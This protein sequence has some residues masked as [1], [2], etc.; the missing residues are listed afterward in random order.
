MYELYPYFTND[1]TVGLFSRQD[2]D[3]YHSTYGALTESWQ[4][5]IIPSGLKEHLKVNNSVKILDICYGIGYNSKT[6]LNVFINEVTKKENCFKNNFNKKF[7]NDTNDIEAIYTDNIFEEF[8]HENRIKKQNLDNKNTIYSEAIHT[9]NLSST[10]FKEILI[11]AVDLDKILIELS[12][13][14]N[15]NPKNCLLIPGED[16][17]PYSE[18]NPKLSQVKRMRRSFNTRLKKEF[19]LKKEV[20]IILLEKLSE[21]F[22]LKNDKI[23]QVILNEK[24]Y[25]LFLS[26]Y[27]VNLSK[28]YKNQGYNKRSKF[29]LSAFIHNI[30]YRYVS[31]S[32]K[33]ALKLLKTHKIDMNFYSEDARMFIKSTNHTYDYIF[34]DA[35]T[36]TKCPALWT[37]EFL[38]LLYTKLNENGMIL[39]YSNSAAVRNA[40]LKNGFY[41]GKNYDPELNKFIG[42]VATKNDNLI[43]YPLSELDFDLIHSKAGI[44]FKDENLSSNDNNI[45]TRRA[46]EVKQSNLA[47]SSNILRGHKNEK[48]QPL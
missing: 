39:T 19:K 11:D 47:S 27:M 40:F 36:P 9:D 29:N 18:S 35:F 41:V 28:Y 30:Y 4:K 25:S 42:T 8:N 14:I 16:F 38:N 15:I 34:L 48:T 22:D 45:I 21:Q 23:V 44:C 3:I 6:A 5:F 24:K 7:N 37:V 43:K 33:N 13:F 10:D 1:G 12:P 31:Q 26:K 17:Y 46:V 20:A 32:Y 2:N